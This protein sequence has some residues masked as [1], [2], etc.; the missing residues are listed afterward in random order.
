[1]SNS[2]LTT[3]EVDTTVVFGDTFA[4]YT[5]TEFEEFIEPFRVRLRANGI[6]LSVFEGKRCLDA[7]CGGGR[8]SILMAEAGAAEV[9]GLDLSQRNVETCEMRAKQRNLSNARFLQGSLLDVP[10]EDESFDVVWSNGVLHHTE[11]PDL[12]LREITRVLKPGGWMW[13]YLYG[14][15]G[16]YWYMVDW[17]RDLLEGIRPEECIYQLRMQQVPTRRVAEWLD[18]WKVPF[19]RRYTVADVADRLRELGFGDPQALQRGTEYDTSERRTVGTSDKESELMGDG[20]VR[21]FSQKTESASA[22]NDHALPDPP[23]GKG[24]PYEDGP[25]VT[26]FAEP[27]AKVRE[28]LER[29]EA[30]RGSEAGAYRIMTAG[31]VHSYVRTLHETEGAFD[32]DALDTRLGEIAGLIDEFAS[33]RA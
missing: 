26:R 13:L 3:R 4:L 33:F 19:L 2:E 18:D 25:E 16:I 15:G 7:G 30:A 20:D 10:F 27:L 17:A 22:S 5:D 6:D 32:T 1:M 9:V 14:S 23:D 11:D 21:F 24:S 31:L 29:L 8:A 12:T 28:A